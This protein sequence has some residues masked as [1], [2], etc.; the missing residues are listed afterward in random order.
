MSSSLPEPLTSRPATLA[1][2]EAVNELIIAADVAVQG[3]S[4]SSVDELLNWW[5]R[6]DPGDSSWLVFDG[7]L[8]AY[9]QYFTHGEHAELDGFVH[10][11]RR[12]RG[13]GSWLVEQAEARARADGHGTLL[14]FCLGADDAARTL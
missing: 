14:S 13:L 10:P 5:R 11:E 12:G 4:E 6:V 8:A 9:A 7:E 1:D 2:A 3:W